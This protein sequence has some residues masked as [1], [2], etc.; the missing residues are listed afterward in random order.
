MAE[1]SS[2]HVIRSKQGAEESMSALAELMRGGHVVAFTGAGISASAGIA[3][4]RDLKSVGSSG[5]MATRA[6]SFE[7]VKNAVPTLTH[8]VLKRLTDKGLLTCVVTTNIDDLHAKSGL[9]PNEKQLIE[10]HGNLFSERC[11]W[12]HTV[13]R[14][15][16][17]VSQY[18]P[19]ELTR[20]NVPLVSPASERCCQSC[21]KEL[22]CT[23]VGT[24][25][26]LYE[27][28]YWAA[29]EALSE[30]ELALCIGTSHEVAPASAVPFYAKK[31]VMCNTEQTRGEK[32]VKV[33]VVVRAEAD[34]TMKE[35]WDRLYPHEV[36]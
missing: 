26:L 9:I 19:L 14:R 13:Y 25:Q 16:F 2:K 22:R 21:G 32:N 15:N 5:A 11:D 20:G 27:P 3:T 28:T 6:A 8:R 23:V 17:I 34:Q 29:M 30:A 33:K 18:T 1:V 24:N 31:V 35:L 7:A 12:C 36:I 4:Y 10:L